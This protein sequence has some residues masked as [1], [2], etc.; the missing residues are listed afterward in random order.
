MQ[1]PPDTGK[2]DLRLADIE[3]KR[4]NCVRAKEIEIIG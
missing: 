3:D 4:V 1:M 2:G